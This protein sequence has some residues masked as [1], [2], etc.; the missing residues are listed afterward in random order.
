MKVVILAGGFGTRLSEYTDLI[1][2]PLVPVSG[3]PIIWHIMKLY[4]F[5]G[6]RKFYIALGYKGEEIKKFF[7]DYQFFQNDIK[8]LTKSSQVEMIT[9]KNEDWEINLIETGAESMTGGRLKRMSPFIDDDF[10]LTYGDGIADININ[11]LVNFHIDN[12]KIG[13][14]T[15]VRPMPKYG[16]IEIED[17]LAVS[18]EEKNKMKT[19]WI[20]G[21]FFVFKKEFLD[22]IEDDNTV[23][24]RNP[25][26]KISSMKELS[27]YKH[28]GFWQCMDTKRDKDFLDEYLSHKTNTPWI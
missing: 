7:R 24:E 5:Y 16:I 3:M 9:N 21:G 27:A 6:H 13:T 14:V 10:M 18:F 20:N 19:G 23:L 4:S 1:P 28:E 11:D 26:E 2:K 17:N 15:C 22:F 8:I 12:N 25:L